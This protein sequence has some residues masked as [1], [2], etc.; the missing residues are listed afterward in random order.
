[1]FDVG[2][3]AAIEEL[4]SYKGVGPKTA[5]CVLLLCLHRASFAVDTHI[6]RITEL[7]GWRPQKASREETQAH[8]EVRV[9]GE[10][11]YGL[12]MLMITHGRE[13]HEC[14]AGGKDL[15]K[16]E[17]RKAFRKGKLAGETG[18][19]VEQGG[20]GRTKEEEEDALEDDE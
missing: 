18:E 2:D 6:Y 12:H 14:R 7:L 1:M 17:L 4:I 3:Q 5:S 20:H 10:D 16:C 9:P 19:E 8:L 11:K 13:C 15:R